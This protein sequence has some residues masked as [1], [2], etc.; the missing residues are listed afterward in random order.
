MDERRP[1]AE[2]ERRLP[3]S[4]AYTSVAAVYQSRMRASQPSSPSS[5][6]RRLFLRAPHGAQF[7][8]SVARTTLA[9]GNFSRGRLTSSRGD[10]ASP[11]CFRVGVASSLPAAGRG[12]GY[13]VFWDNSD[14]PVACV[15]SLGLFHYVTAT[16]SLTNSVLHGHCPEASG[17]GSPRAAATARRLVV[18]AGG[19]RGRAPG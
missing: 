15:I 17:R 12:R 14:P 3:P 2:G 10:V 19:S 7:L 6:Q 13:Q 18:Q 5:S 8:C 16:L 1:Q 11:Y 4:R 9:R